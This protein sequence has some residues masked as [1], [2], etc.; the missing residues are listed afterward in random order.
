LFIIQKR[1]L[2]LIDTSTQEFSCTGRTGTCTTGIWQI[3]PRLFS[4]I[5]DVFIF[6]YLKCLIYSF[7]AINKRYKI[8][9]LSISAPTSV[10][11]LP[12]L[13]YVVDGLMLVQH[14]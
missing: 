10:T 1:L 13:L 7:R 4:S 8:D 5:K 6:G 2:G 14:I 3:N 12:Y 9:P 11:R